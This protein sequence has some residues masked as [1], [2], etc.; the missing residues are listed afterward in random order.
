MQALWIALFIL[1][2][3][4]VASFLNVCIDRLPKGQ[5]LVFPASH[6]PVCQ[7][8]LALL[9][10]IP[11]F[12]YL[13]L[14]GRCRYCKAPIPKRIL[15]VEVSTGILFSYLYWYYGFQIELPILMLYSCLFIVLLVIDWEHGLILNK[16]VYP[17]ALVGLIISIFVSP[18]QLIFTKTASATLI[19]DFLPQTGI[20]QALIG[21]SF[22]LF[23]F[24]LIIIVSRGGMGWGD[25][26]MAGLVGIITGYLV[27][28]PIFLAGLIGG[29]VA[30]ALIVLRKKKRG[31]SVPF[32]PFFSMGTMITLL[33][34]GQLLEWYLTFF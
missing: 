16:I 20:V 12:S 27:F 10:L 33:W 18:S 1:L 24:T 4:I 3:I 28:L 25:A 14:R 6:C 26:K 31:E 2:G 11:V 13:W 22:G 5:S 8:R 23:L 9:D 34:G 19:I 15:I 7:R 29:L 32:G 17:A 21:G 30:I